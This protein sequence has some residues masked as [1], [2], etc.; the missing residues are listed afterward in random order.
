MNDININMYN[1]YIFVYINIYVERKIKILI[2]LL[3]EYNKIEI[4]FIR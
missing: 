1:K 4:N 3:R 2:K